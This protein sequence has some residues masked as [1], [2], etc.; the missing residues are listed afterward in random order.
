LRVYKESLKTKK[1][2]DRGFLSISYFP[3]TIGSQLTFYR[4]G[5]LY[6]EAQAPPDTNKPERKESQERTTAP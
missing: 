5:K 4:Q 2:Y 1:P 3:G 6:I